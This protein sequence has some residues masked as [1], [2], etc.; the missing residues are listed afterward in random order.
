MKNIQLQNPS[1]S[2]Q[3]L[4]LCSSSNYTYIHTM[5]GKV[6]SSRTLKYVI[7]NMQLQPFIKIRRG[8]AVNPAFI[9]DIKLNTHLPYVSMVDGMQFTISRRERIRIREK[10]PFS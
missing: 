10:F 7:E 1:L 4:Y 3:I 6:L 5:Q 8:T 2:S 9:Q